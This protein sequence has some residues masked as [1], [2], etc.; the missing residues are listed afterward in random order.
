[1]TILRDKSDTNRPIFN[2][3]R[4]PKYLLGHAFIDAYMLTFCKNY[5]WNSHNKGE[6]FHSLFIGKLGEQIL[7]D[8]FIRNEFKCYP[9]E[10][11][12]QNEVGDNG[13]LI[14]DY[15]N[16]QY[17]ISVKTTMHTNRLLTECVKHFDNNGIY[18]QGKLDI[19]F[20]RHYIVRVNQ[21]VSRLDFSLN[22]DQLFNL[23]EQMDWKYD[24]PGFMTH[25]DFINVIKSNH[26]INKGV[27][28]FKSDSYYIHQLD[29]RKFKLL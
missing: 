7:A 8:I 26:I 9:P 21:Y 17:R 23:I 28:N 16:R 14:I 25:D 10:Y 5:K 27:M 24:I 15:M 20:D 1:M 4:V 18:K 29:L 3:K 11:Y 19:I 12:S 6:L 13:D 22:R 2:G